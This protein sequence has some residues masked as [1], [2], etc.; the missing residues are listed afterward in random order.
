MLT[1]KL[2]TFVFVLVSALMAPLAVCR[3]DGAS[4]S[5]AYVWERNMDVFVAGEMDADNLIVK[6]SNQTAE[7]TDG[8]FLSDKD[9]T[10]RATVLLDISTSM[11]PEARADIK[12]YI[13]AMIERIAK[14]EQFKIVTFGE[15]LTVLQDFTSDRYDLAGA[16]AKIEFNGQQSR[17]YDAIYN[18]IPK[19][20]PIEDK[21]CY[22]RTIVITDGIDDTASGV[23]KEELYLKLQADAYPVDVVAVSGSKQ[24]EPEKELS[25]LTRMSGGRYVNLYPES[26]IPELSSSLASGGVFWLRAVLPSA[27]LDGSTRQVDISDGV[28]SVQFDMKVSV[29]DAPSAETAEPPA[30]PEITAAPKPTVSPVEYEPESTESITSVFGDYTL[31]VFIGAGVLLIILIAVI[32]AV[33]VTRGKKKKR[34]SEYSA[35]NEIV[36]G[37]GNY[38]EKTEFVGEADFSGAQFT[39]KLSNPDNPGKNWILPING[40]LVIG[41]AEYCAIRLDDK[42]VSRE[43]CKIAAQGAGLIVVHLSRTNKTFL[44]GVNITGSSPLQSGCTLKFGRESLHIDYIQSLGAPAHPREPEKSPGGS[45]TES[46]F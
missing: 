22:Y 42:S 28:N 18:T 39:I 36:S 26:D 32:I 6:V 13:D 1:K 29:F 34:T 5:Q 23:T 14:N 30:A 20:Q 46:I 15:R 21:P 11:P 33:A 9:V 38:Y 10:V 19:V 40:E 17:I 24:T 37:G 2:F 4:L 27:L 44:N 35:P 31:V 25:A 16:A 3:A 8:G 7:I 41:R 43:Q 45:K 12:A